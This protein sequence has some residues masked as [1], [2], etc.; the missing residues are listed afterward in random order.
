MKTAYLKRNAAFKSATKE[1]RRVMIAKDVLAQLKAKKIIARRGRWLVI[2]VKKST[3]QDAQ[4][5]DVADKVTCSCCALGSMMLSEIRH[6]DAVTIGDADRDG[7]DWGYGMEKN[8]VELW[9]KD[10][11][12]YQSTARN[13]DRLRRYFTKAQ[14][15][16]I[17][18]A[19]ES[20]DGNYSAFSRTE[21]RAAKLFTT[22]DGP[23]YRMRKIME[24]IIANNGKFIP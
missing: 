15:Q 11:E 6:N 17:E 5:C 12:V 1:Q 21:E 19:F 14:L 3:P 22:K 10:S 9:H 13:G 16:L 4:V 24:N 7:R 18:I 8:R 2:P 20:G 23:D